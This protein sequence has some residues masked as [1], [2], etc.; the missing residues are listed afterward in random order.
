MKT[1]RSFATVLEET[2]K[3]VKQF[4]QTRLQLL[5][6]EVGEKV[7][8]W[9][10]SVPLLLLAGGLL[11]MGALVLTF[12]FVALIRAW[13]F[14]SQ[15]AWLWAGLIVAALYFITGIVVGWFAYGE[16]R[17]AG[18]APKRTLKVLKQDQIWVQNETSH[19]GGNDVTW[20][21]TEHD[22]TWIRDQNE[23]RAA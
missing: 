3:E 14:P 13:F 22:P 16:L 12:A 20:R 5:Q 6:S 4:V 21:K 8:I 23:T 18:L 7:R 10:Y 19:V 17:T 9:K 1:E 11:L 15:Y 2:K